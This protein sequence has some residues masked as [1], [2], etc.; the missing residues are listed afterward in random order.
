MAG[1]SSLL[2]HQ[3]GSG[4]SLGNP[5]RLSVHY[6]N[7]LPTIRKLRVS[8]RPLHGIRYLGALMQWEY[9]YL[10]NCSCGR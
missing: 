1:E 7:V 3:M 6:L 4:R 8:I 10:P 5:Q 2:P 9:F